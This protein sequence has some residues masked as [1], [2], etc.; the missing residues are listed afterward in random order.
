MELPAKV[1][2]LRPA[3]NIVRM[4]RQLADKI[5]SGEQKADEVICLIRNGGNS[6]GMWVWGEYRGSI[7]HLGML[8]AAKKFIP[9]EDT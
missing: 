5:E 1:I 6:M 7:A 2:D 9:V 3:D 4:F 8:E